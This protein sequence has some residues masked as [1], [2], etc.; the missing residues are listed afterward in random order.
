[1]LEV[2]AHAGADVVFGLPGTHNLAFWAGAAEDRHCRLVNVRH[3]QTAVYAADGW[4]RATGRLGAAL[5]TTGPGAANTLGAF[6]EAAMS[7]SALVLIASE[8][9]K[10]LSDAGMRRTLHQSPDQAG[11]FR[12]LAKGVFTPRSPAAAA[13]DIV[14]AARLAQAPPAGPVYVDVPADILKSAAPSLDMGIGGAPTPVAPDE[15]GLAEAARLIERAGSVAIWAG[16]GVLAAGA[17][18]DVAALARR[19]HAPVITTFGARGAIGYHPFDVVLPPHEPE[20]E[21][22]LASA[23]VLVA[24]GTNFDGMMT[25]NANLRLPP[26]IVNVNVDLERADC[27]YDEALV[28]LADAGAAARYFLDATPERAAGPGDAVAE[29]RQKVWQ[30]LRSDARTA[31]AAEFV[32]SVER[33]LAGG[34]VVVND[35]TI[36]GYWLGNYY[37]APRARL[38]QYPVGWGTLGYALPASIGAAEA[39]TGP[40]LAVCGDGG[41]MFAVGELG[42]IAQERLPVTVLIVDDG[43]YGML[44]YGHGAARTA[45]T[46]LFM[47]D[48]LKLADAF[49]IPAVAVNDLGLPLERALAR[50]VAAAAPQIVVCRA[51]LTPPKTTSPRWEEPL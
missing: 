27:G 4:A 1:M 51:S 22:L 38:V 10:R 6:G 46:D 34:V 17:G 47:P 45:G 32:G 42:T 26:V 36:A 3:E 15:Q 50:S 48:F 37:G 20:V 18:Q 8:V 30:R 25:K 49:G 9:P 11:M 43:G 23:E 2:L 29:L 12:C 5:V 31:Q 13:E 7:G 39:G 41:L 14:A 33:A 44:R 24:L 28:V 35:M 19:W 40:V 16:G 21:G